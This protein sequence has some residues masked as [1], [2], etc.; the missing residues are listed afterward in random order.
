MELEQARK[1]AE[2]LRAIIEKNNRL[3]YDQDAPE[4]EDFEYDALTREL[5]AIEKEFPELVTSASPTQH[6]GGTASA[7][8]T[9]VAH[10]VKME[11]L[12]DAFSLDELRE[13]DARVR[14][15]GVTPEYVVEAK[16]DGLSVS[17]EYEN[18]VFVRGSTRGD[19]LVGEDVTENLAVIKDI[20]HT[21]PSAPEF[22]EVRGEVYMPHAAF[23]A[24]REQ[25]ELE[26][27]TP[28][29]NPRNAAAGSL[30]QKDA[31]I[32]AS[33][34]LSIFV[35]NL[36]RVQGRE[37][38]R[39][40]ETLDYIKSLGFPVSPRYN[41]YHS[42]EDAI[43][44][45]L[46]IG[47]L[48]GSLEYDIDGAVIK[49]NDLAARDTLGSTNKF[50]RWAIAFKYPPEVKESVVRD[51][52][53]TVGR[54]GVL[55]PTAVFDPIF[56]AGTSVARASL[57]NGDII[58]SLDVRIGDTIQVRKA[59]DIIPEVIGVA[60][61]GEGA[62][63]YRMPDH[64]P[65]CGAPVVHLEDETAL[66]CVNPEC[67]AQALRNLIHFA[68]RNAMAIDGLGEAVARQLIDKNL[69]HT[70]ADLYALTKEQLLTLDKF[71]EKSA[72]N[73]LSA[74][75]NSR[76]NNLDK[77]VF[78]LG[79]RNI[80]DKAAALLAEHF[81]SMAALRQA[82]TEEISAIDGFGGVMAQSVVE[83]FAKEGTADLLEHLEQAN[84][85]M[86]WH[87]EKKGTALAGKTLVVT[88]TLPTL[89]R[90]EAE[91]LIVRNGGKASGS[92]SKRTAYVLAGE[93]AGSKLTK[94]QALGVPVIDEAEFF[95]M[96]GQTTDE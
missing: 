31:K 2:E 7:K 80:G 35:F 37:F 17:L 8:F 43:E 40:S 58:G 13:F 25:Q 83:F 12:Q 3:Y 54:T 67:P 19:G 87:G 33:R 20:P 52:E 62:V 30:R 53:V 50:P 34:G 15:A 60:R 74:I 18:G 91:A 73:L 63:P 42:I 14:E 64:C 82:S 11:S 5:S 56:L 51:I 93:A 70:V 79:I 65:S 1:R 46:R 27:K 94:A 69:V 78:G 41:V 49:V 32:T 71:K 29:K 26:D 75:D 92:V 22:L 81:G 66:R 47:E 57:H 96:I 76:K 4:L 9:K 88:G 24:L 28:F 55:T 6:V 44:E 38:T 61:H 86:E 21:L 36:Q 77:L 23:L 84:V 85:N 59:G 39:H 72:G 10:A 95:R 16:I 45:I 68:S 48:R 90:Q 89:S